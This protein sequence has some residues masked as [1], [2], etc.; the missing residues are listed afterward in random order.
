M[1]NP[2]L[3]VTA[4]KAKLDH[5][6]WERILLEMRG[7]MYQGWKVAS[8]DRELILPERPVIV[9]RI[10]LGAEGGKGVGELVCWSFDMIS[11]E[12][13]CFLSLSDWTH[14]GAKRFVMSG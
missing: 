10:R 5:D 11:M 12:L 1:G 2:I 7:S 3:G 4:W 8:R 6:G 13:V 14:F 9:E